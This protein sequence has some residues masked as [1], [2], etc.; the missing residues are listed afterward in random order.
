MAE[1]PGKIRKL[2]IHCDIKTCNKT[3]PVLVKWPDCAHNMCSE[4]A[5]E[6]L[7][8]ESALDADYCYDAADED[9][10]RAPHVK[11][12]DRKMSCPVEG[13][14]SPSKLRLSDFLIHT[15]KSKSINLENTGFERF[16]RCWDCQAEVHLADNVESL[17]EV[18]EALEEHL[19]RSCTGSLLCPS[20][21]DQE[22]EVEWNKIEAHFIEHHNKSPIHTLFVE[23]AQMVSEHGDGAEELICDRLGKVAAEALVVSLEKVAAALKKEEA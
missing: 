11:M 14:A 6:Y 23:L 16:I 19:S 13:C 8:S 18:V 17:G 15:K 7:S 21:P 10:R 12:E 20:C 3:P 9:K 1:K 22:E 4:C 2:Q 5:C